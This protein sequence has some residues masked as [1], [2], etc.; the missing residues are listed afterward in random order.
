MS[1]PGPTANPWSFAPAIG[2]Q[3]P[4]DGKGHHSLIP[5]RARLPDFLGGGP[6]PRAILDSPFNVVKPP[7][8]T[9]GDFYEL[10]YGV[11]PKFYGTK[12]RK[13]RWSGRD[14]GLQRYDLPERIWY[15]TPNATKQAIAGAGVA[16]TV[17]FEDWD[18]R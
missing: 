11:D 1:P 3:K 13:G 17:P 12:V 7:G 8:M 4:Y 18:Q 6:L 9:Q 2:G 5:E 15:G 14:L 16:G 10:H